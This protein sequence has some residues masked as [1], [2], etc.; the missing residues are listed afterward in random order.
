MH[1]KSTKFITQSDV[2]Q[3]WI[4]IDAEDCVLGRL[5]VV[6]ADILRGKNEVTYSPNAD[7]GHFVI[8][9]NARKV[10]LTGSK[11][12][13]ENIYWH[14]GHPGGIKSVNRKTA[15]GNQKYQMVIKKAIKGMIPSGPLGYSMMKKV[16]IYETTD[17]PHASQ[18]PEF[19]NIE[20][21][22]IKNKKR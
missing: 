15:L 22:N 1:T 5:A 14:T 8:I 20:T 12:L 2:N 16:F 6:V 17:H 11:A 10:H 3:K 4:V 7:T 19:L 21:L 13:K 9:V 18:K